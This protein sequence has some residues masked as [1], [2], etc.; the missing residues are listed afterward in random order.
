M[1]PLITE[2]CSKPRSLYASTF[3]WISITC[4]RFLAPFL[5]HEASL[6]GYEIGLLLSLQQLVS[7]ITS[8]IAGR[9]GDEMELSQGKGGGKG[10]ALVIVVSVTVGSMVILLH[11]TAHYATSFFDSVYWYGLL[12]IIA[13]ISIAFIFPSLDATCLEYLK[14]Q[15][16][17][18]TEEFGQ[19]RL[20]GAIS[21]AVVN[22]C[23]GYALDFTNGNFAL[24]IY[25]TTIA[26]TV[27]VW[28]TVYVYWK[29]NNNSATAIASVNRQSSTHTKWKKKCSSLQEEDK[30]NPSLEDASI[31]DVCLGTDNNTTQFSLT[32]L[33][34][35][36][37]LSWFGIAFVIC[38]ITLSSGQAVVEHL[39]FLFFEVLGSTYK[40]M[41]FTVVL[42][43]A[44]EIPIFH[45]A[46]KLLKYWGS[47]ILLLVAA[48]CYILRVIGYTL[49][50]EGKVALVLLFEPLHGITFACSTTAGVDIVDRLFTSHGS[51][52]TAQSLLQLLVGV[53][54]V[55]GLLFGGWATQALG[56][57]TM[58]RVSAFVVFVGSFV[59]G[60][61][62]ARS[63]FGN[64]KTH[65][66]QAVPLDDVELTKLT[67]QNSTNDSE[68][69]VG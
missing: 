20:Y 50:P 26:S 45:I 29:H 19:E 55:I 36:I 1:R 33:L 52:A 25:P 27:L 17:R 3:F 61:I 56:P 44:F 35:S 67:K 6:T 4:G 42:T 43:V 11:G 46:P 69:Q 2:Y 14:S 12:R 10:R 65:T 47:G 63:P 7:T 37:C 59:F 34:G 8:S 31:D 5:E 15:P 60:G 40:M 41:G 57:R 16:T 48:G 23:L 53:G 68:R 21:W 18:T 54:S 30:N 9:I 32:S 49:I 58:Y 24:V 38:R 62:L 13:A 28:I 64:C 22:V 66:R 39:V 51:E